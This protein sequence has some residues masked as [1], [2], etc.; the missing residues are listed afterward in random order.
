MAVREFQYPVYVVEEARGSQR[1]LLFSANATEI[2]RWVGVPQRRRLAGEETVGWQREED[3]SRLRE[4]SQFFSDSRNVVQN[5]LLCALQDS[6]AITFE[7]DPDRPHFGCLTVRVDSS[8]DVALLDSLERLCQHLEERVPALIDHEIDSQRRAAIRELA[9][10][11]DEGLFARLVD[12]GADED[13]EEAE[14]SASLEE[15]KPEPDDLASALLVEETQIVDFYQELKIRA[16][17][18]RELPEG[19]R[20]DAL[21]GFTSQ[22]MESYLRPVVLVDGQHRLHGAVHAAQEYANSPDGLLQQAAAVDDGLDADDAEEQV[23]ASYARHLPVSLLLDDSPAEHVF[24]FVVVNQ[25]ATP[26]RP[27]LLGTIVSTSLSRDEMTPVADRLRNAGIPFDDSQ[28]VAFMT[29]SPRSPFKDLVQTGMTGDGKNL[30]QWTVLKALTSIFRELRGGRIFGSSL[31][32]ADMWK[33]RH[34]HQS[35]LV[36]E[37]TDPA[38]KYHLWSKA[39]GPWRDIAVEFFSQIRDRFGDPEDPNAHNAWG[40]TQ[41]NLYNKIS[42]TI[43]TADYFQFLTDRKLTLDSV[44]D[45]SKTMDDWLDGVS[46]Q[47]FNRDWRVGLKKDQKAVREAWAKVWVEYRKNPERLPRVE[48]YTP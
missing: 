19:Q 34:L 37:A 1:L 39:D 12:T 48:N 7:Q 15:A 40:N 8:H 27:A 16:E 22:A 45:V 44:A 35:R 6:K 23:V 29:R 21:A 33:K 14:V 9:R 17:I 41:F 13:T 18:L 28:A 5:P 25:K 20:P 10:L 24:Q 3:A 43:L 2:D 4:L 11:E 31:D 36:S 26:M 46:D 42:L 38:E 30:L 47:Y 32:Y